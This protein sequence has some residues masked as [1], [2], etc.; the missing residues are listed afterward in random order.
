MKKYIAVFFAAAL[1]V[2]S[3]GTSRYSYYHD[4]YSRGP[5]PGYSYD[6]HDR[7]NPGPF[8]PTSEIREKKARVR[9]LE[10]NLRNEKQTLKVL[11]ENLKIDKRNGAGASV[12]RREKNEIELLKRQIAFDKAEIK[13][14]KKDISAAR[15][16][17]EEARKK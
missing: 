14:L 4:D 6:G 10:R 12:I 11:K 5:R 17:R 3:C 7:Y 2:C 15:E 13:R 1:M 8:D 16:Y 9:Q